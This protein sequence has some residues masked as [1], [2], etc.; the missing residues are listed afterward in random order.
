MNKLLLRK[1]M[2]AT[3]LIPLLLQIYAL[4]TIA[5]QN[6]KTVLTIATSWPLKTLNPSKGGGYQLLRYG[7]GETLIAV[8]P[9]GKLVPSLAM[10]WQVKEDGKTWIIK[11]REDAFFHDSS[12]VNA[13]EVAKYL[14]KAFN[15]YTGLKLA[16]I[17]EISYEDEH[18]LVIKTTVPF[19][20]LPAYLAYYESVILSPNSFNEKGELVSII[21]TG[22]YKLISWEP[23]KDAVLE[24]FEKHWKG[25]AKIPKVILKSIPDPNARI[26]LIL[27]GEVDIAQLLP[28]QSIEAISKN[29]QVE[30]IK[31]PITRTRILQLNCYKS[32]FNDKKARLAIQYAIDRETIDKYVFND[33]WIPAG[34]LFP[35]MLF[36][37][38]NEL[39]PYPYNPEKALSLLK[40]AGY[41]DTDGDGILENVKTGEKLKV[42]FITYSERA[43]LPIIA[44]VIQNQLAKIGFNVDLKVVSV[45]SLSEFWESGDF[46]I[47]L[48]ARGTYFLPDPDF[49]MMTDFYSNRNEKAGWGAYG[50]KNEKLD[51]LLEEGRRSF[52]LSKR[53]TIYKEAQRIIYEESPV[54]CIDYYTNI[55]AVRK[56]IK[57]YHGHI[58]EYSFNLEEIEK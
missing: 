26:P 40:E 24:R 12:K 51:Q 54:I 20:P 55:D 19:A 32:P 46:D 31:Y 23:M 5:K 58:S 56:G 42:K 34:T 43:E 4:P 25:Q 9:S 49:I 35:P 8:D 45:N 36:W 50:W 1:L 3:V 47:L 10:S 38:D 21:A 52:D 13:Q 22:P 44:E 48:I 27:A 29:P 41:K 17:E 53:L 33:L 11:L 39:R 37:A 15:E 7:I 6:E 16:P 28:P 57:N 14:R 18:T 30:I 2:I